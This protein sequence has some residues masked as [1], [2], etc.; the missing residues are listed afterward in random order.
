MRRLAV[1]QIERDLV[2]IAPAPAFGRIIALDDRV[3]GRVIMFGGVLVGRIV[4][5]AD[6]AAGAPTTIR[7]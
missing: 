5:A 2:N 1:G 7:S 6:M 3:G 4:A